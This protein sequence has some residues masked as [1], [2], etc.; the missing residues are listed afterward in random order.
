MALPALVAGAL[1]DLGA[2]VEDI[3][4][5]LRRFRMQSIGLLLFLGRRKESAF[6][7]FPRFDILLA[8]LDQLVA[9]LETQSLALLAGRGLKS[10][11]CRV[12]KGSE[13]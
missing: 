2:I 5:E 8:P 3:R 6:A 12:E 7:P 9:K 11:E 1:S 10:R 13:A 4:E